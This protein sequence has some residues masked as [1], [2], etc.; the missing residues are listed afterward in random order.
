MHVPKWLHVKILWFLKLLVEISRLHVEISRTGERFC[1]HHH[2][3]R[4]STHHVG[5]NCME[6]DNLPLHRHKV[7][8]ILYK[9]NN[10]LAFLYFITL[11]SMN[12]V[13]IWYV[14]LYWRNCITAHHHKQVF[15]KKK[16]EQCFQYCTM[17][18]IARPYAI[19]NLYWFIH[20]CVG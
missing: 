3:H 12:Y 15:E 1:R 6:V 14:L 16:S 4:L 13:T 20:Q 2:R 11:L 5:K 18:M 17:N 8:D 10:M 9:I 7:S 19:Q